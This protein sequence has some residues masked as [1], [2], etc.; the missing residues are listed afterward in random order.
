MAP[1]Q[2]T[3]ANSG[4]K[5]DLWALGATL[6]F[7]LEGKP[8]FDKGQA[9]PTLAAVVGEDTPPLSNGSRLGPLVR[10]LMSKEPTARPE[11]GQIRA[12]LEDAALGGSNI[13]IP[14]QP[15]TPPETHRD[16]PEPT[17]SRSVETDRSWVPWLVGAAGI[18]LVAF[19]LLPNLAQ[20]KDAPDRNRQKPVPAVQPADWTTYREDTVGYSIPYPSD[21]EIVPIDETMTDFRDPASSSYLRVDW[22]DT[23][24][25][26]PVEAWE[27]FEETFATEHTGYERI[28]IEPT[29]FKGMDAAVWEFTYS[30]GGAQLHAVDLGFVTEDGSYGFALNFQTLEEDWD[31]SQDTFAAF[32]EGFRP[33]RN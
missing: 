17:P 9:L 18:A 12:T 28:A 1:E 6:Y 20:E 4:P 21:W 5:A 30:D 26:S 32:Q 19:L 27:T 8:P 10:D 14:T 33:P 16:R 22:T 7:A 24:G 23:P 25:D 11:P 31:A 29:T 3:S 13:E 2:A 15:F